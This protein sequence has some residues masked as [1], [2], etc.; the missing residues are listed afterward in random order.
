CQRAE[1]YRQLMNT[2][3]NEYKGICIELRICA[4]C[5]CGE[6]QVWENTSSNFDHIL[7]QWCFELT[8]V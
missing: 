3:W 1:K 4:G 7:E 2:L 5:K 6:K 8:N